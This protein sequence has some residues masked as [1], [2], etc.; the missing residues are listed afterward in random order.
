MIQS[1]FYDY[2]SWFLLILGIMVIGYILFFGKR[3]V[4][5]GVFLA[6]GSLVLGILMIVYKLFAK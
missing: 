2:L 1:P 5:Q 6:F 3:K 4:S